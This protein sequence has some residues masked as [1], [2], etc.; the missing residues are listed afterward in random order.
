M[1][2][3]LISEGIINQNLFHVHGELVE[4]YNSALE[5]L[6]GKRTALK[7]FHID[8]R[9]E[10]PEVEVELGENTL[11][12]SSSHRFLII[13]SP[14]QQSAGLIH[15]EFSFDDDVLNHL[16][17]N[18]MPS[19]S[20]ATR[21][22]GLYGE[23][24]DSVRAYYE[25]ED[26]LLLKSVNV[27]LKS[28]SGFLE[29][30]IDTQKL[31]TELINDPEKLIDNESKTVR[32]LYDLA[33]EVGDIMGFSQLKP[34]NADQPVLNFFTR[35]FNGA[36]VFRKNNNGTFMSSNATESG[37]KP[38]RQP[39]GLTKESITVIYNDSGRNEPPESD[40]KVVFIPMNDVKA[41]VNFL[42]KN[43]LVIQS[44]TLID[45]KLTAIEDNVLLDMG[46]R[47]SE[48]SYEERTRKLSNRMSHMPP[49]WS[50]LIDIKRKYARGKTLISIDCSHEA[51]GQLLMPSAPD[52]TL[53]EIV[54][55]LLT[56]LFPYNYEWMLRY[57]HRDLE[58]YFEQSN[59]LVQEY[60]LKTLEKY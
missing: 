48:I 11:Q 5:S 51:R 34:I 32:Y 58:K 10:S 19:I 29:K 20:V 8:K 37:A 2:R 43:H 36:Y 9:G 33:Q 57:N 45:Q 22:D 18:F 12:C 7:S 14:D 41:V 6:T 4:T 54:C 17:E 50:E 24:N 3:T 35:L 59:E 25:V 47:V 40:P 44:D 15:E 26:L 60:L 56:R 21:L 30:A 27:S 38:K 16:Y 39:L 53:N 1:K 46:I 13:L 49:L 31:I 52:N 55:H 28:T 42:L 23:L